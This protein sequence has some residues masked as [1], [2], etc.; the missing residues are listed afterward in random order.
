MSGALDGIRVIDLTQALAGPFCTSLLAD[1]GADVVKIEPPRGDMIRRTGPFASDDPTHDHGN[2]FQNANRNKRSLVIDLKS[3]A[4]RDLVLTLVRDADVLVENFSGGVM[5]RLGLSYETL[6]DINPRL[7]YTSIRGFGDRRGGESPYAHW[8]AF[9]VVAQAMGGLMSITGESGG[10]PVRVGSGIGDTVPALFAAF[11]TMAALFEAQ[12]SGRGQY[13]DTAMVDG[14]LAVSE[15]AVNVYAA[16]GT[17]PR[18]MGNQLQGFAPFNTLRAKDGDV[19]LGAPHNPQWVK[20]CAAMGRPDLVDDERFSS[21]N[22]RWLH[23]DQVYAFVGEWV[24]QYT[25]TELIDLLGGTVPLGP[26]LDSEAIFASPHFAA[27][28]MLAEVENPRTG[29]TTRITGP[30]AKLTRTP[31]T[32][33]RRAPLLGEHTLEVLREAGLDDDTITRLADAGVLGQLPEGV[34]A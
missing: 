25:I 13:V 21:D 26:V 17:S 33:R 32:I 19:A 24:A 4:G 28:E 30:V 6:A 14:V 16:T 9:D 27:R 22:A 1:Y 3:A 34:P 11:G 15:I 12:R 31:A 18:P 2:V 8:P 5:D 10:A 29:R 23:R 7:V 20:L